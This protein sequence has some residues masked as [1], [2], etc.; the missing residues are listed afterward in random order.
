MAVPADTFPPH[1]DNWTVEEVLALP[2]DQGNRVELVDGTVIVSPAPTSRHQ[3]VLQHIQVALMNAAPADVESL[4]GVNVI[5]S[6]KRLLIP[7]LAV[8][9]EPGVDTVCYQG[10]EL[11]LAVE[12]HSPST[13]AYD[14][15][16]KRQV[17]QDACV[18]FLLFVDPATAPASATLYRLDGGEYREAAESADGRLVLAEPFAV[19]LD[20]SGSGR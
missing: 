16:L 14:R 13:R 9:T 18:P 11:L 8:I 17:Y 1:V 15:A 4:P 6:G 2:E 3:R 10:D 19:D 20:L 5:L 12:I 7:D